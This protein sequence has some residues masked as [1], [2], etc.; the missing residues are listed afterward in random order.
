MMAFVHRPIYT[1]LVN[2]TFLLNSVIFKILINI[3]D[4][5]W[6][7]FKILK[8]QPVYDKRSI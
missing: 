2:Y 1:Y 5:Y 7:V 4:Q 6:Q 3:Q 8:I